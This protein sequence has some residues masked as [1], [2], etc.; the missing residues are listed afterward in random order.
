MIDNEL[1][2]KTPALKVMREQR[3]A[4]HEIAMGPMRQKWLAETMKLIEA[5]EAEDYAQR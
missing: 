1:F 2:G 3:K 5:E 4:L